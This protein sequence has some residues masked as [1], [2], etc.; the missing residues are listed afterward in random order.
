MTINVPLGIWLVVECGFTL[1]VV[2]ETE[3]GCV[4]I[5]EGLRLGR[6]LLFYNPGPL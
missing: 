2:V 6:F 5:F 4:G 3:G 1:D